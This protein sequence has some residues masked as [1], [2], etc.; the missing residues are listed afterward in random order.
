MTMSET[1]T[2]PTRRIVRSMTPDEEIAVL[3]Q[4]VRQ[5][6]V[7]AAGLREQLRRPSPTDTADDLT[8]DDLIAALEAPG[9]LRDQPA[10][11]SLLERAQ[12][13][14]TPRLKVIPGGGE[15]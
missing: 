10:I 7:V 8:A 11:A 9:P 14:D 5:L 2:P 6:R 1:T 4:D 12:V 15:G 13:A 3:R